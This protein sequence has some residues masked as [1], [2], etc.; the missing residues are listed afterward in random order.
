MPNE[1]TRTSPAFFTLATISSGL[2][3]P[4]V[5]RRSEEHTSELQSRRDLVCRL[6]LEKKTCSSSTAASP[7]SPA[8]SVT[9]PPPPAH[10]APPSFPT[11]RSS[12]LLAKR[13]RPLCD[14]IEQLRVYIRADAERK[15]AHVTGFF[16]ARHDLIRV[17]R[18]HGRQEIGRAHV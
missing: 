3:V 10:R 5:G 2:R 18:A 7:P 1:K 11:R 12:D 9:T 16:Y 14:L 13:S 17:A 6:L 8:T 15:D 4:T